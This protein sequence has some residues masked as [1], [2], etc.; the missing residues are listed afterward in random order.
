[1]DS[2]KLESLLRLERSC[3]GVLPDE[4]AYFEQVAA[5]TNMADVSRVRRD[6]LAVRAEDR[7]S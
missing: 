5:T 7:I 1:V 4:V 2:K 6:E 3:S